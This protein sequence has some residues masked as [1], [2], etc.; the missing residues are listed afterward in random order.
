MVKYTCPKCKTNFANER[1]LTRHQKTCGGSKSNKKTEF[2]CKYCANSFTRKDSLDRHIKMNRCKKYESIKNKQKI[3]GNNNKQNTN[4][5]KGRTVTANNIVESPGSNIYNFNFTFTFAKDG[6]K[7]ISLK[8]LSEIVNSKNSIFESMIKNVN[9][10]PNKPQHHNVFYGNMQSSYGQVYENKEWVT[11]KIDEMLDTLIDAKRED[12]GE[13]LNEMEDIL[14]KKARNKIKEAIENMDWM[15]PRARKK[16]KSYLKPILYNHKDLI[17]KT[18]KLTEEQEEE[19]FRK[20]QEEA[21]REAIEEE[22]EIERKKRLKKQ[23]KKYKEESEEK[24]KKS[25]KKL[26]MKTKKNIEFEEESDEYDEDD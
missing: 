3:K 7:S 24:P 25:K 5:T 8:D 1:N 19:I 12:L 21:E 23:N 2:K 10:N 9:L 4:I 22:K 6:I 17:I 26:F 16:L 18:R 11:K 13:I 20:E 15:N 14:N